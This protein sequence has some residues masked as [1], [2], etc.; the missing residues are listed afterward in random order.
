MFTKPHQH[1]KIQK[2]LAIQFK[3]L[4]D[5]V[6]ITPALEAL[7]SQYPGAEIH[8][9]VAQEVVPVLSHLSYVKKVWGLPRSRGKAKLLET[10]PFL[11][12]LRKE[13]FDLSID[14]A[15]NDRGATLSLLIG[16]KDRVAVVDANSK[17]IQRIAY[18]RTVVASQLP[19]VWVSRHLKMLSILL[20]TPEPAKP[21]TKITADPYLQKAAKTVL[22]NHKVICHIGTSQPKKEWPV[23]YW[24]SFYQTARQAGYSLAFATGTSPREQDLIEELKAYAPDIYEL[25]PKDLT[26]YLAILNEAELVISGDTGPLHFAAALDKKIIGLFAV[27]DGVKHYAPIYKKDEIILGKTCTCSDELVHFAVCKSPMP[28][29]NSISPDQVFELLKKRYPLKTT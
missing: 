29:M 10:F 13:R 21:K 23:K 26:H 15:G 7:Q 27:E 3:Y 11:K 19:E 12:Q 28:C 18:T 16:A 9:L 20:G 6:F 24:A 2:I 8:V 22:N 4:G 17:F 25:R 14:F 5:A 1:L